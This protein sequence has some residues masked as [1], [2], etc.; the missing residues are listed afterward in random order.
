MTFGFT[1][2]GFV[3]EAK[4]DVV[5]GIRSYHNSVG[6]DT[7]Q[8]TLSVLSDFST[9]LLRTKQLKFTGIQVYRPRICIVSWK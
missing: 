5:V 4:D 2:L 9:R 6:R 1:N 8:V 3:Q 7:G